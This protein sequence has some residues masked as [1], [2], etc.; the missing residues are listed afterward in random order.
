MLRSMY[1]GISG[2]KV[3]Q[4]KLD[5]LGN[6]ISNVSTTG[7][8]YSRTTFSEMLSQ[9]VSNANAPSINKG[10][11][12]ANQVGLGVQLSSI[13]RIMTQG[14]MQPTNRALDVAIDGDGFFMVSAGPTVFDNSLQVN[15][16]AGNH[17]LTTSN[18]AT[19]I[20][21]SRDGAFT[22]DKDGNLLTSDG[23]RVMGY[24]LT[25]DDSSMTATGLSPNTVGTSGLDF[26]FGPGTQLNGYKVVL[27][28]IGP[29][30]V[31]SA[32]VDTTTKTIKVNA[33]FS[34]TS[35]VTPEQIEI[36]LKK[37][38]SSAGISQH[39]SV[40]GNPVKFTGLSTDQVSGG[41]DATSPNS[42]AFRGVTLQIS[43]GSQLNGYTFRVGKVGTDIKSVTAKINSV[44][45]EIVIDGNFL[46]KGQITKE[47]LQNAINKA[48]RDAEI[49]QTVTASGSTTVGAFSEFSGVTGTNGK[50]AKAPE[51]IK[52]D[53]GFEISFALAGDSLQGK[54]LEGYAIIVEE[55]DGTGIVEA[56]IDKTKKEIRIKASSDQ[57]NNGVAIKNAINDKLTGDVQIKDINGKL[58][59]GNLGKVIGGEDL[60]AARSVNLNGINI[61]MPKG[62]LFNEVEIVVGDIEGKPL[63]NKGDL[64]LVE[65]NAKGDKITKITVSGDF[66]DQNITADILQKRIQEAIDK[67][68]QALG[69]KDSNSASTEAE[70]AMIRVMASGSPKPMQGIVTDVV[71]GG[72]D[73]KE[74]TG[75]YEAFDLKFNFDKGGKLNGY[76]IVMGDI[77]AGTKTSAKIDDKNKTIVVNADLVSPGATSSTTIQSAINRS[78]Q[79]KGINQK[80]NVTGTPASMTDTQTEETFGGTPVSS[81]NADGSVNFVDGTQDLKSFDGELKTLK[82]PEKVVNPATGQELRVKTYTIDSNGVI[83]GVLEDG[84]VSALGQIAIAS[85]KN[86]EGLVSTGGNL[87]S[88]SVNSGDAIIMAGVGTLADDN[89]GGYGAM[90][91]GML[92]MSNVDL[93][94]QFTEMITTT[95]AFQASGKMITTGDE[96]LQD[97]I[98]LKR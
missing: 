30:T 77:S 2:M 18:G 24:S 37:G 63:N 68:A 70:K 92:E 43:E 17:N 20:M 81:V 73:L 78:L 97:I 40:I 51:S 72:T 95:R 39:V 34:E 14:N 93:S 76:K 12:N 44:D 25:N 22:L 53:A 69:L 21:Y 8:K 45:K 80:V 9:N 55:A 50:N 7:F 84:S 41:S 32:D 83:N 10:G 42:V 64:V 46:E 26:K 66:K 29:G 88:S 36:A 47:E 5:V 23:Y 98:N 1:S 96:I 74:P 33:D 19:Q 15:H 91:Q 79:E 16:G 48:L 56:R 71:D 61:T 52:S 62:E 58:N 54:A 27:G 86:A 35:A 89:S 6:N 13:D 38:L 85:F 28:A 75:S 11:T 65:M 4:V 57:L 3:N 31:T 49:T 59:Y 87:Y 67:K 82:I 94:E 60:T 90:N